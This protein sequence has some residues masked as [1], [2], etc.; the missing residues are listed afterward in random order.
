MISVHI[1]FLLLQVFQVSDQH[2]FFFTIGGEITKSTRWTE[3]LCRESPD[4]GRDPTSE[5]DLQR[6]S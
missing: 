2:Y 6:I 4:L 1:K 5:A 3:E